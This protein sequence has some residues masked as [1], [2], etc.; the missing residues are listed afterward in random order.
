MRECIKRISDCSWWEWNA[1][2]SLLFWKCPQLYQAWSREGQPNYVIDNS[3]QFLRPQDPSK[4]EEYWTK[5]KSK[6][7][8][9]RKRLY[10]EPWTLL[11]LTHMFYVRKYLN[12]IWMVYNGISCG[13]NLTLWA[14]HFI[15]PMFQNT[16]CALLPGY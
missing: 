11:I 9:V 5:M 10:I 7:D 8:K 1:I 14:P 15:L 12:G 4:T 3:P 2:S 16:L 13:F 6:V